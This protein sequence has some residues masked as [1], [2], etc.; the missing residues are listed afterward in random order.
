MV[1]LQVVRR[2][3]VTVDL[4][5]T[6]SAAQAEADCGDWGKKDASETAVN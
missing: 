6:E 5:K 4:L 1:C 3:R 2:A